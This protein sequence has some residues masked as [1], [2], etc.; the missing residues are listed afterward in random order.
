[1][2]ERRQLRRRIDKAEDDDGAEVTGANYD[3]AAMAMMILSTDL[4]RHRSTFS[5]DGSDG[6]NDNQ[7][8]GSESTSS[9][10]SSS[11][12]KSSDTD[13][14]EDESEHSSNRSRND[15]GLSE[16]ERLRLEN[17]ERNHQRLASL[18]LLRTEDDKSRKKNAG[19]EFASNS[20][21]KR[22]LAPPPRRSLPHRRCSKHKHHDNDSNDD[23]GDDDDENEESSLMP[24]PVPIKRALR[25]QSH[26]RSLDEYHLKE[27][28][29]TRRIRRGRPRREEYEYKCEEKCAT[30]GGG[31]IFDNG[32]R[33]DGNNDIVNDF[34]GNNFR[35]DDAKKDEHNVVD[36]NDDPEDIEDRTR[37]IRCKD[38]RGAFHLECMLIHG[39]E[40]CESAMETIC[41]HD[42]AE[43]DR[44]TSMVEPSTMMTRDPKRC[45]QCEV[46]RQNEGQLLQTK[47]HRPF[48]LATTC[49]LTLHDATIGNRMVVVRVSNAQ[50]LLEANVE[51]RDIA[52]IVTLHGRLSSKCGRSLE[53]AEEEDGSIP[54]NKAHEIQLHIDKAQSNSANARIQTTSCIALRNYLIS[55]CFTST[56][57]RLG[58]IRMLLNS[59]RCHLDRP[60][61][62]AE[63]ICTLTEIHRECPRLID[64]EMIRWGGCL[65]L[66]KLAMER[67]PFHAKVQLMACRM[68]RALSHDAN[69]CSKLKSKKVVS[70]VV[71]SIRRNPRKRDVTVEGR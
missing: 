5:V 7:C 40:N 64:G 33:Y 46:K 32:R 34:D 67:H 18:G 56:V 63:A 62:Q 54:R 58:G 47:N 52:C 37:L 15:D 23:H 53:N 61:I 11:S 14:S 6:I 16:Y 59:L 57:A 20:S 45:Y 69:C 2:D 29:R 60:N 8:D 48:N 19:A 12:V 28:M 9:S 49:A 41:R 31:W 44:I 21:R 36:E 42:A 17:I 3:T 27:Y 22:T 65:D 24:S 26:Q 30:C 55:E 35:R 68:F 70:A 25:P 50:V 38:C 71:D 66:A 4:A 13:T 1:M 43:D 51:G 39:K 10:S